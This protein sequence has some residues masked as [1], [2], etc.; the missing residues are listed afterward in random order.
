MNE[1]FFACDN[2][3][4]QVEDFFKKCVSCGADVHSLK[5]V[6]DGKTIVRANQKPYTGYEK[7]QLY[8]LSKSFSST[9]I[10]FLVTD[11]VLNLDEKLVDIFADRI[12]A[13]VCENAK[14][15]TVRHALSM[16]TG[17]EVCFLE[18]INE[19]ED[20]IRAWFSC[21]VKY[22]PGTH[23]CYNNAATYSLSEIVR[24]YTG[25]SMFDFLSVR[26]FLPL[27][28][29]GLY[30]DR[31][32]INSQGAIGLHASVDDIAKLGCLYLNGGVY[33]GKRLLSKSWVDDAL[34]VHSDNS[35]N[36][37]PDWTSGYGY[38]FWKNSREGFRG[39]GAFGQ[40]C[41][42]LPKKNAVIA[43]KAQVS[44]MQ[45]EVDCVF[46]L[47]EKLRFEDSKNIGA[48]EC[49][50]TDVTLYKIEENPLGI[51]LMYFSKENDE[52]IWNFS[53]GEKWQCVR[54][55]ADEYVKNEFDILC[56]TP[57]LHR[58]DSKNRVKHIE[59]VA[60]CTEENNKIG[61]NITY[62]DNPHKDNI[63]F[64]FSENS[65]SAEFK[66]RLDAAYRIDKIKGVRIN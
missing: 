57:A 64:V 54:A 3:K 4:Q 17:H 15:I 41:V 25:M 46:D 66:N 20:I 49:E 58:L 34:S 53:N 8:S 21:P 63:E 22:E 40:L 51:T 29:K 9:A 24:K 39:D 65:V 12:D 26:L 19:K 32:D 14:K 35:G 61:L 60:L 33:N 31:F 44:D 52:I 50:T 10:G 37:T 43:L 59:C 18:Q 30:W 6:Y 27:G 38:Q 1:V 48:D 5:I 13:D 55:K 62:L 45:K 42:I 7:M 16:N 23:F 28:M 47:A 56:M 2:Y 36:G 11:G